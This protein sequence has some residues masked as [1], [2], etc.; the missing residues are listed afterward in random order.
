MKLF[1][2]S[3]YPKSLI[4]GEEEYQ[5]RFVKTVSKSEMTAGE[6]DPGDKILR[7]KIGQSSPEIFAT[8]IHEVLHAFETE[9]DIKLSHK[10]VY[11]LE[12]AIT[13][14]LLQNF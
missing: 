3:Q 7:I 10:V 5:I 11:Q 13:D 4:I 6:C 9:H 14:L 8:F 12:R 2:R 1:T